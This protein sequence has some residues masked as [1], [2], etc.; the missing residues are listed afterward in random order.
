V[1]RQRHAVSQKLQRILG[2]KVSPQWEILG[3]RWV[4]GAEPVGVGQ[5]KIRF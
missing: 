1:P 3:K 5:R 2:G 4:W